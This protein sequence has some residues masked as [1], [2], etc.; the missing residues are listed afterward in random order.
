MT[1]PSLGWD[2]VW[3]FSLRPSPLPP[4]VLFHE[5]QWVLTSARLPHAEEKLEMKDSI[6]WDLPF[7]SSHIIHELLN[8]CFNPPVLGGWGKGWLFLSLNFLCMLLS[9]PLHVSLLSISMQPEGIRREKTQNSIICTEGKG[10]VYHCL[11]K[12]WKEGWSL[13]SFLQCLLMFSLP[14][15]PELS[16]W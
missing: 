7:R 4:D 12:N 8:C 3:L 16:I 14:F 9:H 11:Q 2:R 15:S 1:P 5:N 10:L 13:C 6:W